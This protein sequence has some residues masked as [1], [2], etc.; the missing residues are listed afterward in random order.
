MI[1]LVSFGLKMTP[2]LIAKSKFICSG[3]YGQTLAFRTYILVDNTRFVSK[4]EKLILNSFVVLKTGPSISKNQKNM[5]NAT[6]S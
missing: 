3:F 4:I 6:M 2:H 5:K 1:P